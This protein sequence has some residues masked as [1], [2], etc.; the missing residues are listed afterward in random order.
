MLDGYGLGILIKQTEK[1]KAGKIY[2][3]IGEIV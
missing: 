3:S 2:F 1:L